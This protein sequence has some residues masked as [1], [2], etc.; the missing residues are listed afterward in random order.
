MLIGLLRRLCAVFLL[1]GA[2]AAAQ[3]ALA[4]VASITTV[5][6]SSNPSGLGQSVTFTARVTDGSGGTGT[7]DGI[8]WFTVD[9]FIRGSTLPLTNQQ[10]TLTISNLAVGD[11]TVK[12]DYASTN[13]YDGSTSSVI[14]QTVRPASSTTLTSSQN[15]SSPNSLLDLTATV[16]PSGA[17]GS[18]AFYDGATLLGTV[19]LDGSGQAVLGSVFEL[20]AG[21]HTFTAVYGGDSNLAGSTSAPL[22]QT[23]NPFNP[24]TDIFSS[25]NPSSAGQSVTFRARAWP[26][27][28][29]GGFALPTGTMTFSIDGTSG[30]PVTLDGQAEATYT[31]SGLAAGSHTVTATYSGD[32][33]FAGETTYELTQVVNALTSTTTV[34]SS[35][36]PS[37]SGGSVTFTAG[38]SGA[39]GTPTGTVTFSIDGT[40]VASSV[41]LV[42]GEASFTTSALAVGSHSVV[43]TY[44]GDATYATSTSNTL[45]QGVSAIATTTTLTPSQ[46]PSNFGQPVTFTANVTSTDTPTGTVTFNIDGS[47]VASGVVLVAGQATYTTSSLAA[48]AHAV[49]ATYS[50]DATHATSSGS[51]SQTVNELG[52]VTI[53]VTT[54]GADGTF[55]F[56]SA[57]SALTLSIV[58]TGGAGES[59]PASL[60]AGSY[61]I[62]A[63][64]AAAG[65]FALS[66]VDCDDGNSSGDAGTGTATILLAPGEDVTCTFAFA[67]SRT[68][69]TD[70]IEDFFDTRAELILSHG[71]NS[72]RRIDRLNGIAPSAGDPASALMGLMPLVSG[73]GP[74]TLSGSLGAIEQAVA[75]PAKP[76]A[77]D[78]WFEASFGAYGSDVAQGN[79]GIAYLGADYLVSPDLLVGALFQLDRVGFDSN[80][81]DATA[82]GTGWM[83]GPYVTGRLGDNLYVDL[84][85][86]A[87]RSA[88]SISPYGTYTDE[89]DASRWLIEAALSGEWTDGSWTF[90]PAARLSYFEESSDAYTDGLGVYV[91]SVTSGTGQLALGP[92]LSYRFVTD[93]EIDVVLGTRLDG[94]LDFGLYGGSLA[95]DGVH[96]ELEASIDL[97]LPGGARLGAAVKAGGLGEDSFRFLSGTVT[98]SAAIQ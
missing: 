24:D 43:V 21:D 86:A 71:P 80:T 62:S 33:Y 42:S 28:S 27:A 25:L 30:S 61:A 55:G 1:V 34:T 51:L 12:A 49:L 52:S 89:V 38:V 70:L 77:L 95:A 73:G 74:R 11:H 47:N 4:Q 53:A 14:T 7:P 35:L 22:A 69:A 84:R 6:S 60:V 16:T 75:D 3:P 45:S 32:I 56:T 40:D 36:N 19:G 54:D 13:G 58:T 29:A 67:D 37:T 20:A 85:A 5:T 59:S 90:Q 64:S 87:G 78:I 9:G 18:V 91:P 65:G 94:V 57:T 81:G 10:A 68:A 44:G 39:S 46:N 79:F 83:I 93:G 15:P 63:A 2:L 50:G 26:S 82:E 72:R 48:G 8:V 92:A 96:A 88:N 23:V 41:A 97:S 66:S 98:V 31:T 17:T 76:A